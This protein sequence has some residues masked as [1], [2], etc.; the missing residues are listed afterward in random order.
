MKQQLIK[1][2]VHIGFI[3]DGN[4]RWAKERGMAR[5]L[6]HKAGKDSLDIVI[7]E[8][9]Y[10]YNIPYISIYAFSTE[11]WNRPQAEIDYLIKAFRDYLKKDIPKKYPDVRVNIMGD[12]SR[13]PEDINQN[14]N[15]LMEQT[16]KNTKYTLNI[17]LNY[18]G[19]QEITRAINKALQSGANKV[20]L[21]DVNGLLYSCG[22][23]DLDFIVRTGGESRLSNFM[24][25]QA[26]YAE[27]YFTSTLWP[28]FK[29]PE[30]L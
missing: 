12:L 19:Q 14:A 21:K 1:L 25:W 23:P 20:E 26:A 10:K 5:S 4:G 9:F 15:K 18:S 3:M 6:G 17:C 16:S 7:K 24:L 8:C 22:Q 27:L 11:N 13:F 29:K 2:P 28:D 30:L